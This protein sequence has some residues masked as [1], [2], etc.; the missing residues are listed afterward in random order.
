MSTRGARLQTRR[1]KNKQCA[2]KQLESVP[3]A[4]KKRAALTDVSNQL[5][6]KHPAYHKKVH[7]Y[8]LLTSCIMNYFTPK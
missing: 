8:E 1:S 4:G 5:T 6:V 2:A 3:S 7:Y